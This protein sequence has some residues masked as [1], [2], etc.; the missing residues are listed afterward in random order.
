MTEPPKS[1]RVGIAVSIIHYTSILSGSHLIHT[2]FVFRILR[3]TEQAFRTRQKTYVPQVSQ[4]NGKV[5]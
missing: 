2:V 5:L 3:T 4:P 1:P